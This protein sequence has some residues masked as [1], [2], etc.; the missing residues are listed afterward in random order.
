[1][2]Q[3]FDDPSKCYETIKKNLDKRIFLIS[4]GAKGKL[5]VPNLVLHFPTTFVPNYWI[6][7]FCAKMNMITTEGAGDPTNDWAF[8]YEDHV[9]MENHQDALL[10][11]LVLDIA[12]YF[13]VEGER[14]ENSR[15]LNSALQYFKWSKLMWERY[16]TMEKRNPMARKI[17][18]MDQRIKLIEQRLEDKRNMESDYVGRS[19]T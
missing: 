5:I 7:I 18:E 1:M 11:R 17:N 13:A 4:S 19:A 16:G 14:F 10:A 2:F 8:D 12:T 15:Q 6:Y 9:V 3:A